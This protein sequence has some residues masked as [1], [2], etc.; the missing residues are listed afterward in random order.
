MRTKTL[1]LTA[2]LS[3]AGVAASMAQVYSV[4]V[5]G[6][7]NISVPANKLAILANPLSNGANK[8][9]DV[10]KLDDAATGTTIYRFDAEK[11]KYRDAITWY[12]TDPAEGGWYSATDPD[13]V[14]TPGEGFWV[15]AP[16]NNAVNVT[17]VGE[18]PQGNLTNPLAGGGRLTLAGSIVPQQARLGDTGPNSVGAMGFPAVDGDTVYMWDMANQ[19]YKNAY[20]YYAD[21]PAGW[22]ANGDENPAGPEVAVANGFWVKKTGPAVNWTR[23]FNVQ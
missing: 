19:K 2:A 4:N 1:L 6:Y 21:E 22:Y 12:G 20:T 3:A 7:V 11:Q 17:F 13:P 15:K 10:L 8:I 9:G 23:T 14:L 16:K 5:V 18:V